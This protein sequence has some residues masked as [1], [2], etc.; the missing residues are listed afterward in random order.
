MKTV[1]QLVA[2]SLRDQSVLLPPPT[3]AELLSMVMKV[4]QEA[5]EEMSSQLGT[6]C[7]ASFVPVERGSDVYLKAGGSTIPLFWFEV[8]GQTNDKSKLFVLY[9]TRY[10]R[11]VS[12]YESDIAPTVV[13]M[14]TTI[15]I[16]KQIKGIK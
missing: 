16:L 5:C 13:P 9:K 10:N 3:S 6:E 1:K 12:T 2:Q 7:S 15:D 14:M 11:Y 4:V 8:Q